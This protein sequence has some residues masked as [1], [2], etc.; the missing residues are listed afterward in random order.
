MGEWQHTLFPIAVTRSG[1]FGPFGPL[2]PLGFSRPAIKCK[3]YLTKLSEF[4][5]KNGENE[6]IE[7]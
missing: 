1:T 6:R 5:E 4:K 3:H 2:G 7:R